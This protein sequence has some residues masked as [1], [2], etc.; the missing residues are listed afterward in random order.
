MQGITISQKQRVVGNVLLPS[1]KSISNRLLVINA[2]AGGK[3]TLNNLSTANDTRLLTKILAG[4]GQASAQNIQEIN[5]EDAGTVMRFLTAYCSTQKGQWLLH[6]TQRMHQR[7][8]VILAETL[9]QLGADIKYLEK[10]GFPPLLINGKTLQGGAITIDATIS[11]QYISALIMVAPYL[12]GGLTITLSGKIAS[13]PYIEMT[14]GLMA[15]CGIQGAFSGNTIQIPQGSYTSATLSV[16]SDW[17]AAS[18]WY[19]YAALA[20]HA[21]IELAGLHKNSLQGDSI[22]AQW[23]QHFGVISEYTLNGVRLG[24]TANVTNHFKADFSNCPDLAPTFICL[25][26]ALAIPAQFYGVESLAIKESDRTAVLAAEL[27]KVGVAFTQQ[28]DYWQLQPNTAI[29]GIT[30]PITFATYGDHRMAMALAMFSFVLP[31]IIIENPQVV[32]KSY[33]EFWEHFNTIVA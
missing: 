10:E 29:T 32:Q 4:V 22:V 19:A 2:L 5:C 20:K 6:G 30:H 14:L 3:L 27:Q 28:G 26:A 16:E 21:Q 24:K 7:P 23:M 17:S 25:C 11:S 33:P 13:Q 8:I 15:Q 31:Q 9:K 12:Q 1:S 18:Y